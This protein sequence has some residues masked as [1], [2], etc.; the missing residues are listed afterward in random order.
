LVSLTRLSTRGRQVIVDAGHGMEES[1][2]SVILAVREVVD[3]VRA[4]S[5]P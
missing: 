1:P 4:G 5:H 3:E 2:D